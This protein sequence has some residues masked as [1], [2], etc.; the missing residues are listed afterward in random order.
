MGTE[1]RACAHCSRPFQLPATAEHKRFCSV[2]C[3]QKWHSDQRQEGLRLLRERREQQVTVA[4]PT[5]SKN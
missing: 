5:E 4:T 3:R 2:G 1:P